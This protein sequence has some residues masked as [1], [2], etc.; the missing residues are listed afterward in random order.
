MRERG[1]VSLHRL[2]RQSKALSSSEDQPKPGPQSTVAGSPTGQ[3]LQRGTVRFLHAVPS[4]REG[5]RKQ[6]HKQHTGPKTSL[7]AGPRGTWVGNTWV[8]G[9]WF[10]CMLNPAAPMSLQEH[11][12]DQHLRTQSWREG[13][14]Q[15]HTH[16]FIYQCRGALPHREGGGACPGCGA[17][18]AGRPGPA[19]AAAE[20]GNCPS[21]GHTGPRAQ[22]LPAQ[23]RGAPLAPGRPRGQECP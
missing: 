5:T 10:S 4:L 21:R 3:A 18:A 7:T 17:K 9:G 19:V 1:R 16:N 12:Q 2:T 15:S 22:G 23:S 8:W 6:A 14:S 20:A 13:T 11:S